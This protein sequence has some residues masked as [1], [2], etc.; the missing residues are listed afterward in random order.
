MAQPIDG[1]EPA[2]PARRP[3]VVV[4]IDG[5][6]G[7]RAGLV[8]AYLAAARRGAD[9]EVVAAY[10]LQLYW[11]GGAPLGVPDVELV[12]EDTE[13]RAWAQLDEVRHEVAVSAVPGIRDVGAELFVEQGPA[14]HVLVEQAEGADLLVVGSRGRGATRSAILGSVALHCVTHAPCAVLVV[15]TD[16]VGVSTPP[17]VVVGVDGSEAARAV[18]AAAVDEA[19]LRGAD[20]EAVT[21]FQIT[22]YWTDLGSV[23]VPSVAQIRDGLRRHT[24]LLVNDVLAER[25]AGESGPSVRILVEEGP[26]GEVLVRSGRAADL[27]VVG[28][29]GHGAFRGLLLGSIALHCAMHA[30]CPVLVVHRERKRGPVPVDRAEPALADG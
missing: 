5:S 23:V 11:Y 18:L 27:L 20:V 30:P 10:H 12:R 28:S 9:L 29:R 8:Q 15:H 16:T 19:V 14:A 6:P 22:D 3:R 26:A 2:F 21:T 24:E 25:P 13:R 1:A 17:T 7:S 4:G